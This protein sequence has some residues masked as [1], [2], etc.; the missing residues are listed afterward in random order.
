[1]ILKATTVVWLELPKRVNNENLTSAMK[2]VDKQYT[3]TEYSAR[4]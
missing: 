2:M 3:Y 1:M 4:Y